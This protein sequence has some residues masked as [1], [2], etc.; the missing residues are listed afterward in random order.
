MKKIAFLL[1][2]VSLAL[3]SCSSSSDG[4]S[5]EE[6]PTYAM[7]AKINGTTFQAN[8]PFGGNMFSNTNIWNYYP[9]EDYVMLQGRSGGVWGNPEI[10]IWLKKS[11]IAVGTYILGQETFDTPPSH[12]IDLIDNS[13]DI[14][15]N[16]KN[17]TIIITEV[18]T[19]TKIV[20]GTFQ[21]NTVDDLEN[22]TTPDYSVTEGTFR[23][24]YAE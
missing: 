1:L 12:F 9:L 4:G 17:G 2:T 18:N 21:F 19:T 23:Y 3:T 8:N 20:K 22:Q 7:T 24:Q 10:N 15:E 11:D 6:I 5:S 16:T 14:S 13:N